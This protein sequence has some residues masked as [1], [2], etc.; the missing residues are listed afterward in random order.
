MYAITPAEIEECWKVLK[1]FAPKSISWNHYDFAVQTE[2]ADVEVWKAFL[3]NADVREWLDEERALLQDT[4][5]AKLTSN[6]SNSRSVGQAQLIS[7]MNRLNDANKDDAA[8]G[9]A[10]I[11]SYVPL[12]IDQ[13][14][15]ANVQTLTE[16]IFYVGKPQTTGPAPV[17]NIPVPTEE[18]KFDPTT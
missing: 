2:I 1:T 7:A 10:F 3:L 12:T 18:F 17:R 6:V 5:L 14:H 11:Y 15:A 4:E 9:P 8:T 16:D 13:Q